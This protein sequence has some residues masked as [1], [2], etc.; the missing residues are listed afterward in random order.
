MEQKRNSS[1]KTTNGTI[2]TFEALE[3]RV[4]LNG[5]GIVDFVAQPA[6][7]LDGKIVYTSAGHGL[8]WVSASAG[9]YAGRQE[10]ESTEVNEA[11]GNQDQLTFLLTTC[12]A[13]ARTVVPMRPVGDQIN[14]VVL[15]NDSPGVTFSGSW[16]NSSSSIFYDEDYGVTTDAVPYR[17][18]S[19]SG[20]ETATATYTPDI[21]EAGFYPIYTWVLD[22]SNRTDQLY[23]IN[24]SAGGVTE[25][26]VDHRM[27]GRGWV[28]LGTYHFDAGTSGSVV[29][30]NQST[31]GG[32]VVIADA[33][34]FGNGMGDLPGRSQRRRPS[35]RLDFGCPARGRS[36]A[37]LGVARHRPRYQPV[38]GVGYE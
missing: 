5:A 2:L 1:A 30:S 38:L 3:S 36:R 26:R 25:I 20:N 21:P 24:D 13:R 33:I 14:E 7:A 31:A 28:Y 8:E 32:S 18:A 15:D 27:V 35:K 9:F 19:V 37:V 23:R 6:G 29:I 17:F 4:A 10:F 22:S 34:R 11:F 16:S 12:C